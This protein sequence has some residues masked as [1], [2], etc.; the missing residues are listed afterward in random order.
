MACICVCALAW[1][2][3]GM[4]IDN[5]AH[6]CV[7]VWIYVCYTWAFMCAN[8]SMNNINQN[9]YVHQ[10]T[11]IPVDVRTYINIHMLIFIVPKR[12]SKNVCMYF[13][14]VYI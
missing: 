13:N 6:V 10:C 4:N 8:I 11:L 14:T 1:V 7:H 9:G 12:I 5:L 2:Y 3:L